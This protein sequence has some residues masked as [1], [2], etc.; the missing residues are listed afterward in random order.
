MSE[1]PV[2]TLMQIVFGD[3]MDLDRAEDLD[4]QPNL[5]DDFI[6]RN[7]VQAAVKSASGASAVF[8]LALPP[9]G[10]VDSDDAPL[11]KSPRVVPG[12]SNALA[13]TSD[14]NFVKVLATVRRLFD[15]HDEEYEQ[16]VQLVTKIRAEARAEAI[17][18]A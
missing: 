17:A 11:Y 15:G 12:V 2:S 10:D 5:M 18:S 7:Q 13:K 1:L 8:D 3:N 16:A 9:E 4:A 6:L 14:A